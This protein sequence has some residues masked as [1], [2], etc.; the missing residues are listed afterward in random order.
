MTCACTCAMRTVAQAN[1]SCVEEVIKKLR[2]GMNLQFIGEFV[3]CVGPRACL[4]PGVRLAGPTLMRACY[5]GLRPAR[6]LCHFSRG[7][8]A[9]H[10]QRVPRL[11][12]RHAFSY[13]PSPPPTQSAPLILYTLLSLSLLNSYERNQLSLE[14][15]PG[16][17]FT[18]GTH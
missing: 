5:Q 7:G 3:E 17:T 9:L 12:A 6:G 18:I 15:K 4:Y 1:E 2:P 13:P 10:R 11:P 16:M 8:R 14:L